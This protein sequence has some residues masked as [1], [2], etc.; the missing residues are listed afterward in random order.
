VVSVVEQP[1]WCGFAYGTLDGHPVSGE[2]AFIVHRNADGTVFLTLGSL[3]RASRGNWR[4]AFPLLLAAQRHYRRR[5]L[6]ALQPE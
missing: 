1:D 5:Y 4:W 6:R 3:T 2:K